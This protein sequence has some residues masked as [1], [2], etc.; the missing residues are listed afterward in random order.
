[1]AKKRAKY[2]NIKDSDADG[3][4]DELE[5]KLGTDPKRADSDNDGVGDYEE[6]NV[7]QTDPLNPDTDGDGLD[8]GGEIKR[9]RNPKGAGL[10][11]DLFIPHAGNDFKP[12]ALRP[13]RIIFYSLS[14][15]LF[16]VILVV[17][18]IFLPIEAWLT[19]DIL[20]KQSRKIVSLTNDV[21]KNLK[22]ALLKESFPLNQAAYN[23]AG[24]MLLNQYFSHTGPGGKTLAEWLKETRYN[25][26]VA[27][28]NL[29]M[30][31][32]SPEDV[33]NGW[34]RSRTHYQNMIDPDFTE[35]GVGMASG[36]Y[37]KVD[38]ILVAQ[39]FAAPRKKVALTA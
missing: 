33:V 30:G 8:D 38:T 12:Q 19:P 20:I 22:V 24:D 4:P 2:K 34:T 11:M 15:I 23:K 6:V 3:L 31:F 27:G 21:R 26:M 36:L 37:N 9:G 14:A 10:L 5:N 13:K 17:T 16:K 39:Y 7:Y 28:E 18:V 1:M 32:S 29:A 25:F 35:I